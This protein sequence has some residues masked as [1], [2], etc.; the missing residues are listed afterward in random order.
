MKN[1]RTLSWAGAAAALFLLLLPSVASA[2]PNCRHHSN[3]GRCGQ[4]VY[5]YPVF[6]GYD[7]CGQPV[8][9]WAARPHTHCANRNVA[10]RGTIHTNRTYIQPGFG[11]P[12]YRYVTPY[13]R[14]VV[15]APPCPPRGG[16]YYRH[17]Y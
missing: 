3:C 8:Y 12:T 7:R 9:S 4:A 13:A 5:A 17:G 6:A 2:N 14:P 11:V 15:V 10:R 16:V 1:A